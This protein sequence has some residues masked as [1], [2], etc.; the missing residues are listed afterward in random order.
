ML[1]LAG[2]AE[3]GQPGERDRHFDAALAVVESAQLDLIRGRPLAFEACSHGD[4]V[5]LVGG[6][7][8]CGESGA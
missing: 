6:L 7:A 5:T 2:A 3:A 1:C 8:A 4:D